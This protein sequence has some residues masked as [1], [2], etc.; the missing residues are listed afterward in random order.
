MSIKILFTFLITLNTY[1]NLGHRLGSGP[2]HEKDNI[3]ENS[4]SALAL[5]L[6]GDKRESPLQYK[7]EFVYIEFDIQETADHHFVLF[8]DRSFNRLIPYEANK[9]II[10]GFLKNNDVRR[11]MKKLKPSQVEIL[12]FHQFYYVLYYNKGHHFVPLKMQTMS[13]T[14]ILA[15]I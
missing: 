6:K 15:H 5:A 7:N 9:I 2:G 10:D 8:H 11:R 4:E 1:A 14:L 13:I 3:P 12:S